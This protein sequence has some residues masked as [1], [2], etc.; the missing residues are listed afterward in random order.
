MSALNGNNNGSRPSSI[1]RIFGFGVD[2]GKNGDKTF[3]MTSDG[4]A[5]VNLKELIDDPDFQ[6]SAD[7]VGQ[8]LD[9]KLPKQPEPSK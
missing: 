5:S 2:S 3:V 4:S 9:R 7:Q 1:A 8:F 6:K